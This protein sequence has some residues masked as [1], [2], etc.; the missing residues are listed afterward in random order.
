[1]L[2][3]LQVVFQEWWKDTPLPLLTIYPVKPSGGLQA[4]IWTVHRSHSPARG[5]GSRF[6]QS[7]GRSDGLVTS[8]ACSLIWLMAKTGFHQVSQIHQ[9]AGSWHLPMARARMKGEHGRKHLCGDMSG[10][11]RGGGCWG[12]AE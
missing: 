11:S 3:R 4:S 12:A 5:A 10:E 8:E 2:V 6:S 1:V 7:V 9:R